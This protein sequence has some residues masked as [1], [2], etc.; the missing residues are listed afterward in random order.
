APLCSTCSALDIRAILHDGVPQTRALPL[1]HLTD[2]LNKQNQCGLCRLIAFV[3]RRSWRL[4]DKPEIDIAGI[5]CALY[6]EEI[7]VLNVG[8][9]GDPRTS[10]SAPPVR[11][12]LCHRLRIQTF[13]RPREVTAAIIAAQ[14]SLLLEIQL[15][16]E[17]AS[18]VG[19]TKEL[20]GRRVGQTVDIGLLKRWIHICENEHQERCETMWWKGPGDVLPKCVR[21]LDVTRM[22]IVPAPRSCRYVAL[23][24]I[25]GGPGNDYW[26]TQAN[27]KQRNRRGGL[28]ISVLPVTIRDTIQLVRQLGERYLWI[29]ALC[30]VQ[31]DHK[32]K[33][34]QICVMDL[35]YGNSVFTIFAAGGGSVREPLPG[36]RPGT[37]DPNQQIAKIQGLHLAVPLVLP[38]AAVVSSEWNTRGWTYQE[39]ML[40][41]RR[42]FFT[43]H[44]LHFECAN[45][46]FGED[47]I[48]DLRINPHW[49]SHPLRHSGAGQLM[50][51]VVRR[52]EGG[53]EDGYMTMVEEYTLRK[54]TV[55]HDIVN[56]ITALINAMTKGYQWAGGDP[57]KAF[58]FG[59][60]LGDLEHALVW[61][62]AANASH[63]RRVLA[64]G[65]ITA[66][67]SWS[68][69]AWRGAVRYN[70]YF[71]EDVF[72]GEEPS[73]SPG[74]RESL[75]EQ[76][77]IVDDDGNLVR[78]DVWRTRRMGDEAHRAL[79]VPPKGK[80]DAQQMIRQNAPLRPGTLVFRTSSARFNVT[81]ANDLTGANVGTHFAIY[82]IMS[83]IPQPSTRIG[84][85][86]LP[87]STLS[88]TS[89]EFVVLSRT[90]GRAGLF[91]EDIL[92]EYG[93]WKRLGYDGCMFYV[94]AVQK[95]WGEERMERLGVGVILD[96]AWLHSAAEQKVVF[97]G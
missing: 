48:A 94:M 45:D 9:R 31:D 78:Q 85:V 76:W 77:H 11:R 7:T 62:P 22:A 70:G 84:R 79:Y 80:I 38:R 90:T 42:I 33:E 39:L 91:D 89:C 2:I 41:R 8:D 3:I 43:S 24:Y 40:S 29:D 92:D 5:T 63:E 74:I 64:D 19:R 53:Y 51:G 97:L 86:V 57:T 28:D 30:I 59:M 72:G 58:R 20:H 21:V 49:I 68:W 75:V 23:S 27:L 65:N 44:H 14:S 52:G 18:K 25:W 46:V 6:A 61:Q 95:M 15:L 1:G 50:T 54:L 66:W 82:S 32:D 26:T 87:C 12:D 69:A 17:D 73:I 67:P 56:A 16:E 37:R 96:R 93:I 34:D 88:P 4:D 36:I 35:V 71:I 47:V 83:D 81:K 60:P 55:E 13:H 10:G